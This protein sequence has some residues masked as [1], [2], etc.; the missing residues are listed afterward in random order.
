VYVAIESCPQA[1]AQARTSMLVLKTLPRAIGALAFNHREA[2]RAY[3]G[4]P[5]SSKD[6]SCTWNTGAGEVKIA[7]DEIGRITSMRGVSAP[8]PAPSRGKG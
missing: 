1:E 4:E 3:L 8:A 2:V 5:T 6:D 7:F